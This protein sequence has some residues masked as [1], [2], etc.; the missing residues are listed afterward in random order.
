MNA[1]LGGITLDFN[2]GNA[3]SRQLLLQSSAQV[4]IF[5]ERIAENIVLR[6]PAGIPIFNYAHTEPMWIY[7]LAHSLPPH[8]LILFP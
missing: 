6:E 3:G 5:N 1:H 8:L 4:V 2:L 7:F